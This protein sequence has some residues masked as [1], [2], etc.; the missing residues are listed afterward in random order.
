[1]LG[2]GAMCDIV[3]MLFTPFIDSLLCVVVFLLNLQVRRLTSKIFDIE[4]QNNEILDRLNK[5]LRVKDQN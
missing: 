3:N 2:N 1:M 5:I 4:K